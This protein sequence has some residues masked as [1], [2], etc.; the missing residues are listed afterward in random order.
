[1]KAL[2]LMLLLALVFLG[3]ISRG[4]STHHIHSH[5]TEVHSRQTTA[6]NDAV[7]RELLNNAERLTETLRKCKQTKQLQ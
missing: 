2:K 7:N 4:K 5:S 3:L 6:P 1:M